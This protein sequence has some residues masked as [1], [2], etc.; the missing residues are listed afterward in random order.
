MVDN[1]IIM[2]SSLMLFLIIFITVVLFV[3]MSKKSKLAIPPKPIQQKSENKQLT[4][5]DMLEI[6]KNKQSTK[7]DILRAV[8]IVAKKMKFPTKKKDGKLT[9]DA[10][11][12]LNFILHAILN[13]RSDAKLIAFMN[14]ELKTAN[15]A[16]S[17]EIDKYEAMGIQARQRV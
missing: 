16:Y 15:P 3:Y 8:I 6:V 12:Y 10:I 11:D 17:S 1:Q 2:I 9:P 13:K 7:N 5:K 14:K 4:I